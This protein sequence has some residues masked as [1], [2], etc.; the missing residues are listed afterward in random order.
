MKGYAL[1]RFGKQNWVNVVSFLIVLLI[2]ISIDIS[3]GIA[4]DTVSSYDIRA[5]SVWAVPAEQKVRPK[6]EIEKN[7]LVWSAE[8]KKISIAG[9]GNEHV[10]FQVV[11]SNPVPEGFRP[12]APGG[13]FVQVSDLTSSTG[14]ILSS[15]N[16]HLFVEHYILLH[17]KSSPVSEPGYWP[18]ALVPLKKPFNMAAQYYS[19]VPNKPVWIDVDITTDAPAG[20]YSGKITITKNGEAVDV[21]NLEL[22]IYNFS[23]P[24]KRHLITYI[25]TSKDRLARF[26]GSS[27]SPDELE[28]LSRA[29]YTFLYENR[30]H[31][32]RHDHLQPEVKLN[33]KK[34]EVTFNDEEYDYYLNELQTLKVPL[35]TYPPLLREQ[36]KEE[37]FSDAFNQ[38]IQSY[39]TQVRSYYVEN[40]WKDRLV[41]INPIDEPN[42]KEEYEETRRWAHIVKEV[43]PDIHYMAT[44]SPVAENEDWGTLREVVDDFSV[45]GNFMNDPKVKQAIKEEQ[46]EGG[47]LTWYISC[48]QGYPQPNYFID[49]SALEP[50]MVPWITARYS[51]DGILYWATNFWS[52]VSNPWVDA[53]TFKS[54]YLCSNGYIDNGEG[55]FFYPGDYVEEQTGQPDVYGPVSSIRF[56]LLAEG[57]EDYEYLWM[58]K[59]L[60]AIEFADD[61]IKNLVVDVSTFSR[62]RDELYLTRK[63][64]ARKIESLIND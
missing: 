58:L 63:A 42:T 41:F 13:F 47:T 14:N 21:L 35:Y 56:E 9:A 3:S 17:G 29:Y 51:M 16:V 59:D 1:V 62:N 11:I 40:G 25:R 27:L 12:E 23:I 6:D 53:V 48:D 15:D 2:L 20:I 33:G 49:A 18:D 45:H 19:V 36:I 7:N 54:G 4:Q 52:Q 43:V 64:M 39:L 37:P 61:Q 38:I 28:K 10:P 5:A 57:I 32:W 31:G 24:E 8:S 55:S 22:E 60:G 46:E 44:E 50:I 26:Y 30:M 34:V